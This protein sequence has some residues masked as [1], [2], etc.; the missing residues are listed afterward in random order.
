[1][2]SVWDIP[3]FLIQVARTML[4]LYQT[5]AISRFHEHA[6]HDVHLHATYLS[7]SVVAFVATLNGSQSS[8]QPPHAKHRVRHQHLSLIHI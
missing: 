1:M 4:I 3:L 5:M 6:A 8:A 2:M 7:F